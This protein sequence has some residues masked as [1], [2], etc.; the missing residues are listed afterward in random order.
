MRPWFTLLAALSVVVPA[1]PALAHHPATVGALAAP[2]EALVPPPSQ[3]IPRLVAAP[4]APGLDFWALGALAVTLLVLVL[5]WRAPRRS[6]AAIIVLCVALLAFEGGVHSVHHLEHSAH[7]AHCSI[8][9]GTTH[10][11]G[12]APIIVEVTAAVL[13]PAE[14]LTSTEPSLLVSALARPQHGRAPPSLA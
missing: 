11:N 5:L 10:L 9:A 4:S 8:A 2:Q 7:E 14:H 1:A 13:A 3:I 6:L 12:A